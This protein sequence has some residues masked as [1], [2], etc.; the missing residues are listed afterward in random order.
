ML[1]FLSLPCPKN[2]EQ[3]AA[4]RYGFV[5]VGRMQ[6]EEVGKER[7][8]NLTLVHCYTELAWNIMS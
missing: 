2:H 6:E 7:G 3:W 4:A 5:G 1:V 8:A